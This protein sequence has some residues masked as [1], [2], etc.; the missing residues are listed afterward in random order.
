MDLLCGDSKGNI[1][2]S[3]GDKDGKFSPFK[4]LIETPINGRIFL[5]AG[6][7]DGD[8]NPDLLVGSNEGKLLIYSGNQK[9]YLD[10]SKEYTDIGGSL[11]SLGT[12]LAPKTVDLNGD[13]KNELYVGTK[14]GLIC[15]VYRAS[16]VT[17]MC[18]DRAIVVG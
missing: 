9:T 4:L 15:Q 14:E 7:I 12:W 10:V 6:D 8:G 16:G 1:F 5:D 13:G 3:Y 17:G 11:V 2:V 18:V